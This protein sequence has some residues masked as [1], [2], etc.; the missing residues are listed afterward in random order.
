MDACNAYVEKVF[1]ETD[2]F[3]SNSVEEEQVQVG[4]K[5]VQVGTKQVQTGTKQ[6]QVGTKQVWVAD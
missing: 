1:L 2:V 6:V 5:Q 3:L 4:T